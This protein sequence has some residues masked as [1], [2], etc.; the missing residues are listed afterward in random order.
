MKKFD[1]NLKLD[2]ISK[3]HGQKF[4]TNSPW[5]DIYIVPLYHPAVAVYNR[6]QLGLLKKDFEVLTKV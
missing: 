3:I 4:K 2:S 5:G 1:L 6:N